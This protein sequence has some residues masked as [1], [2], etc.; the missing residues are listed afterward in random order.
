MRTSNNT[1]LRSES[2]SDLTRTTTWTSS[3]SL[4]C[5]RVETRRQNG[6]G[7]GSVR[8]GRPPATA[9]T[10][11]VASSV[12]LVAFATDARAA[13]GAPDTRPNGNSHRPTVADADA[14]RPSRCIVS[15]AVNTTGR[16]DPTN[17]SAVGVGR[18]VSERT[19][20]DWTSGQLNGQCLTAA[21]YWSPLPIDSRQS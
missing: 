18:R 3:S 6:V 2:Q 9:R 14:T 11:C 10:C 19:G 16:H 8:R 21:T 7:T 20:L 4:L 17:V 5:S 13:C 15:G 12:P 1:H